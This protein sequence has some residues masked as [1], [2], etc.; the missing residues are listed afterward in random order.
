M[1]GGAVPASVIDAALEGMPGWAA[2]KQRL[3]EINRREGHDFNGLNSR[4]AIIELA[5]PA[6]W[7]AARE[8]MRAEQDAR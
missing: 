8:N 5:A 7:E 2:V 1:T 4:R 3:F 6:I